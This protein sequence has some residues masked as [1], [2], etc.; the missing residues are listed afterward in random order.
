[1][2]AE[3]Y[4][5]RMMAIPL[6]FVLEYCARK[7]TFS[8]ERHQSSGVEILGMECPEAHDVAPNAEVERRGT[9]SRLAL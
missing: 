7:Q 6:G 2:R 1:M 3:A 4:E 5:L 9:A 8:P